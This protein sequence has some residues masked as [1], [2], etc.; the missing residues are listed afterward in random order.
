MRKGLL[1]AR[2]RDGWPRTLSSPARSTKQ[3]GQSGK[4]AGKKMLAQGRSPERISTD[5]TDPGCPQQLGLADVHTSG[6]GLQGW[7]SHPDR[8]LLWEEGWAGGPT[9]DPPRHLAIVSGRLKWG[10]PRGVR[11]SAGLGRPQ[12][13]SYSLSR[14]QIYI[15]VL[16]WSFW[17]NF[18]HHLG[19]R[20][21]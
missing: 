12:T 14:Q 21:L 9:L 7:G 1:W 15:N 20:H 10:D 4:H 5:K 2:G 16:V 19:K 18:R 13:P 17:L 11:W 3:E 8:N 6:V